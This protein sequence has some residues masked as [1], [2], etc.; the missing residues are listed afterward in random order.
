MHS[1]TLN[2]CSYQRHTSVH[3]QAESHDPI[4][5]VPG[6]ATVRERWPIVLLSQATWHKTAST[7]SRMQACLTGTSCAGH[8]HRGL[9]LL[10]A[11][12]TCTP[13]RRTPALLHVFSHALP[14]QACVL[15]PAA[16]GTGCALQ[17]A[18]FAGGRLRVLA[19]C[20]PWLQLAYLLTLA[21]VL[22]DQPHGHKVGQH[23]AA[24]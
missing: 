13:A 22:A 20:F 6:K 12:P 19:C 3:A 4:K 23:L 11:W 17:E 10:T 2:S 21:V 7:R 1:V 18:V 5:Q 8:A 14:V 9:T 15:G 16:L 24:T